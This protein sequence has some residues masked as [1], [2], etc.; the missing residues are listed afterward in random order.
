[1]YDNHFVDLMELWLIGTMAGLL[2][3]IYISHKH[4]ANE[5]KREIDIIYFIIKILFCYF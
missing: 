4:Q 3:Y 2:I 5:N 1:M